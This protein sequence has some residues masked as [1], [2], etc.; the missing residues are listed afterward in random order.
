MRLKNFKDIQ[1]GLDFT[2]MNINNLK[3]IVDMVKEKEKSLNIKNQLLYII[4]EK[5]S[6]GKNVREK[7]DEK[8]LLG[9]KNDSNINS[10]EPIYTDNILAFDANHINSENY[11]E[12]IEINKN[13]IE[14]SLEYN[15][16]STDSNIEKEVDEISIVDTDIR[17]NII[18]PKL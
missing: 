18:F 9:T 10:T 12:D 7:N 13:E 6:F 16:S 8:D 2:S 3:I 17:K 4:S 15:L 5:L 11:K 14:N 1:L